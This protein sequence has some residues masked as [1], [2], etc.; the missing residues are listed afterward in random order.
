MKAVIV[1]FKGRDAIVLSKDGQFLK[2]RNKGKMKVGCEVD[3]PLENM[4]L[5]HGYIIKVVTAAAVFIL[6]LTAGY[7]V[8]SYSTPYSYIN[9][10]INPS[11]EIVANK[12]DRILRVEAINGDGTEILKDGNFKN[13][14]V[15]SAV[16]EIIKKA[17]ETGYIEPDNSKAVMLTVSSND[18]KKA[19][20][21]GKKLQEAVKIEEAGKEEKTDILVQKATVEQHDEAR[22][23]DISPG[24]LKLIEELRDIR[25]DVKIEDYKTVPV[26]EIMEA[27]V[28]SKKENADDNRLENQKNKEGKSDNE[29]KKNVEYKETT[30]EK[31]ANKM[32]SGNGQKKE[33]EA[34]KSSGKETAKKYDDSQ[35]KRTADKK[36]N[37]SNK[38]K[39]EEG[40]DS[41]SKKDNPGQNKGN[42]AGKGAYTDQSQDRKEKNKE[43]SGKRTGRN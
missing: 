23:L 35:K 41:S 11:V 24:K 30:V 9:I 13:K 37:S 40:K 38:S 20:E 6:T 26:K 3:I 43:S 18:E 4:G 15:D 21:V 32:S 2:V 31:S 8:Y 33:Y 42:S 14:K 19:E 22:K 5:R 39:D 1:D 25:P 7:G 17:S 27:I 10:D 16:E 28:N 36:E 29:G 34:G 12:Y